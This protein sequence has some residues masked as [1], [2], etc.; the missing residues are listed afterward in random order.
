MQKTRMR[1]SILGL[2]AVGLLVAG[3]LASA[4]AEDGKDLDGVYARLG[5]AIGWPNIDYR[6]YSGS[7]GAGLSFV[8]GYTVMDGLAAELE[9]VFTAGTK[10]EGPNGAE[11]G[12]SASN[13]AVTLNAKGYP[14]ELLGQDLLPNHI[15]PY[16]VFGLGGGSIGA[17]D[18]DPNVKTI[19]AFLVRFGAGVDWMLVPNWGVYADGS[20]YV[21][22]KDARTG[23]GTMTFGV[24]YEF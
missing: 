17:G 11:L 2:L 13:V 3:P 9:F 4:R 18:T 15:R 5:L 12:G 14:L 16:A 6:N 19:G 20:Y 23:Y 21:T 8:G 10:A 7:S 24:M 1:D 22:S